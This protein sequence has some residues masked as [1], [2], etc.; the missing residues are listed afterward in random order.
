MAIINF[1]FSVQLGNSDVCDRPPRGWYCNGHYG[2]AGP[3][4]AYPTL[5]TRIKYLFR[6]ELL[7][8]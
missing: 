5:W 1:H 8:W 7:P 3:C 6:G 4:A 2:H